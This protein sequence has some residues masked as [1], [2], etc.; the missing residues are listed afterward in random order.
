[1]ALQ[2]W[3]PLNGDAHNQGLTE[4]STVG[5]PAFVN[6]GILGYA[7]GN[8]SLAIPNFS[9]ISCLSDGH[10]FT[11]C[12]WIKPTTA[13]QTVTF[14]DCGNSTGTGTR[15]HFAMN[16]NKFRFGFRADDLDGPTLT[17]SWSHIACVYDG[18]KKY[19][20]YNGVLNTSATS[21][22]LK[23]PA[24]NMSG[25][26]YGSTVYMNDF[27]LYDTALS[28]REIKEISK[29]KILHYT[30]NR[31]GFG[32][33]NYFNCP[34]FIRGTS[35][36]ANLREYNNG[37]FTLT[38]NMNNAFSQ[39]VPA[40]NE[41]T[42]VKIPAGTYVFSIQNWVSDVSIHDVTGL[43]LKVKNSSGSTFLLPNNTPTTLADECSFVEIVGNKTISKGSTISCRF[44]LEKGSVVTP[45]TPHSSDTLYSKMG[46][47][48]NIE[49]D[50][51]GY[52]H[53]GTASGTTYSS[54]TPRYNISTKFDANT[55]TV[56]LMP[57]FSNGQTV[58]EMSVGIWLKTNT[59][60]ST[61]PNFF[62][63][64]ENIFVRARITTRTSIQTFS[65]IGTGN[66]TGVS[67]NCKNILDNEWHHFV[68]VFNKGIITC[69]IDGEMLSSED[70]SSIA[71]Y[72]YCGSQ[73]WHLA[74]YTA[75]GENFIGSLSD[76]RIYATALSASDVLT[77]Y[78]TPINLS[79][80]GTLLTQ[81]EYVE[82]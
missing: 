7:F 30:L 53:N 42:S 52:G 78:N 37:L 13:S 18:S 28:P 50:V 16:S 75:N 3:M 17:T 47:D 58:D 20:Y 66:L 49:Y 29:G 57:C 12:F 70:K 21:G 24:T 1:M 9:A 6:G 33:D 31:G 71:N 41:Y 8:N 68:Y 36:T 14:F 27:R 26:F 38:A 43:A 62:S 51:S 74:G 39:L 34:D 77:L 56:T 35:S 81:G 59:L 64:G 67:F 79:S 48:D 65:K 69:Y 72:L 45:W 73:S 82:V 23:I 5:S 46:L 55:N 2:I 61:A 40:L 80:N 54:D 10:S 44:M 63:L 32:Q 76:F 25:N 15:L 11:F 22:Q 4:I 19:I 60:N